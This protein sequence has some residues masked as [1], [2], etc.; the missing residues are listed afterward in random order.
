[1]GN[2]LIKKT[3]RSWNPRGWTLTLAFLV[4]LPVACDQLRT[5]HLKVADLH[6]DGIHV[7]AELAVTPEDRQRGLMYRAALD[8]NEGMLFV[9]PAPRI[10]SFWMKNTI[11][12]LDVAY[13][14]EQGFLINY[15]T[16]EPD[17]G[18]QTYR[19]AEP[20]LYALEMSKGWFKKHGLRKYSQLRLPGEIKGL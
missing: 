20:A 16:M 8:E 19:S 9:F 2:L 14:D 17:D 7:R 3:V 4:A 15:H 5:Q 10:Q 1:M 13:F 11:I 12:A 18:K 6:L